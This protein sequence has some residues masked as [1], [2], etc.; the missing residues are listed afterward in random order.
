[1]P[2]GPG[3]NIP[4]GQQRPLPP[5]YQ[6][7]LTDMGTSLGYGQ[8]M[9]YQYFDVPQPS[10]PM[11]RLRMERLQQLRQERLLRERQNLRPDVTSLIRRHRGGQNPPVGSLQA[12]GYPQGPA[13]PLLPGPSFAPPA[14]PETPSTQSAPKADVALAVEPA[15][16]T[17][18]I[19]KIR[20]G[21]AA[22]ILS[23]A[24]IVSRVLGL[25]RQSIFS[26]IFGAE[27][28]SDAY[29]QAFLIPDMI[30]NIVAGGA[31]AS[32]FIPIFTQYMVEKDKEKDAWHIANIALTICTL[33]MVVFAL[34]AIIF[35]HPITQASNPTWEPYKIEL[36]AGLMRVML[37]QSILLGSGVIIN[38]VLQARQNFMLPAIGTVVYN[39]GI[40]LGLV[41]GMIMG[42]F[43]Q[44]DPSN[45]ES[46]ATPIYCAAWGVV[47]GAIIQVVIQARGL[48]NVGMH[49]RPSFDW[50]HPALWQILKQMAPRVLNASMFSLTTFVDRYMIGLIGT[51]VVTGA[52]VMEG[53]T[54][55]YWQA[56]QLVML[57]LGVIGMAMSTAAF[58]TLAEYVARGRMER[59]RTIL[60]ET[61]RSI[62]FLSIPASL[63]LIILGFPLIQALLQGGAFT[64]ADTQATSIVLGF[65][66]LGLAGM[67][68]VEICIRAFY[69]LRDTKTPV[70]VS[71]SQFV[72]KI[73][74]SLILVNIFVAIGTANGGGPENGAVW[75]MGALALAT[76][77][78]SLC[79]AVVIFLLLHYRIGELLQPVLL[80]FLGRVAIATVAMAV[81]L[82]A[83]RMGLDAIIN[84]TNPD[85]PNYITLGF[86]GWFL[87]VLKLALEVFGGLIVYLRIAKLLKLEELGPFRRILNRF[88]LSWIV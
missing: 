21:R 19:Q 48:K 29:V 59:V 76:S 73:A 14:T 42:W 78:A 77:V 1:M 15:Q 53:L 36:T 30:F 9:E 33:I 18:A 62:L 7:P 12:P 67:A 10:Q 44:F 25:V 74:L 71:I 79:E 56:Y 5:R 13:A 80:G 54:T 4:P 86:L 57:P 8:G 55:Q 32:A 38:S 43:N 49:Y 58:P 35:A 11:P 47:L 16:S 39:I 82:L 88:R 3:G 46:Y 40:I 70:I 24:F 65:F 27:A 45:M 84:T 69:A 83:V 23:G 26:R 34:V 41:P 2:S 37:L 20:M 66:A 68:A 85:A 60:L 17:A 31:L 61:L 81:A 72:F 51:G 64:L 6:E 28:V 52:L 22:L 63:G 75:G 87:K 50:K